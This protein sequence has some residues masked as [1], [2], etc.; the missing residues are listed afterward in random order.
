MKFWI[1]PLDKEEEFTIEAHEID[2]TIFNV[3]ALDRPWLKSFSRLRDVEFPHK[4]GPIDLIL[5]VQYSHLHAEE[6][7]RQ[8]LPFQPVGKRTRLGWHVIGSDSS[9]GT[10]QICSI[11]FFQKL[12]MERFHEFETLGVQARDC[13]CPKTVMSTDSSNGYG[14]I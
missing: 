12:N 9:K 14:F 10:T 11:S 2:K 4:A 13:T 3:P 8:G 6:E 7:M 1:S 5:G